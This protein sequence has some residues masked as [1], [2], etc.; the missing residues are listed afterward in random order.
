MVRR[1]VNKICHVVT[2]LKT[3]SIADPQFND[4]VLTKFMNN[5]MLDGKKSVAEKIVYGALEIVAQK[6]TDQDVS[7]ADESGKQQPMARAT[8]AALFHRALKKCAPAGGSFPS[9][10]WCN[11]SGAG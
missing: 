7:D 8:G 6:A 1:K 2:L 11:I 5:I 10:G 4:V 9:C 3:R